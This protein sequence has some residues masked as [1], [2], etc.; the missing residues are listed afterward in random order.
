VIVS[1]PA[2][3][4]VDLVVVTPKRVLGSVHA[5]FLAHTRKK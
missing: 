2:E 5:W 3:V 4:A 1:S